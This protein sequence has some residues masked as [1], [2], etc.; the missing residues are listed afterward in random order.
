MVLH[1]IY[2][3]VWLPYAPESV[4]N[5]LC[6]RRGIC[7]YLSQNVFFNGFGSVWNSVLARDT[8]LGLLDPH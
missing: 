3:F 5:I 2:P 4:E 8:S 6:E 7:L 1:Y